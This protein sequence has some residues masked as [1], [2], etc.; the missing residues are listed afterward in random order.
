MLLKF[1]SYCQ[2]RTRVSLF[3]NDNAIH[4]DISCSRHLDKLVT[5][6]R[7]QWIF[8]QLTQQICN[9]T[10]MCWLYGYNWMDFRESLVSIP[11][12]TRK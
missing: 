9:L 7:Q 5:K 2:R 10:F 11:R 12:R 1:W 4:T 8:C 3:C 6:Q